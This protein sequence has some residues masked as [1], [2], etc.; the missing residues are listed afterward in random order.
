MLQMSKTSGFN[1][2]TLEG[3]AGQIYKK[4]Y[5]NKGILNDEWTY[6]FYG[7][8]CRFDNVKTG[9]AVEF[10]YNQPPEFGYLDGYFFYNYMLTTERFNELGDWFKS[11]PNV[12][13]AIDILSEIEILTKVST[14]TNAR[15]V[16]AL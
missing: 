5:K 15:N 14:S 7:A 2:R 11:Y 9:Q 8:E 3:L 13:E 6:F 10:I 12:W 4:T 16:I 1:I